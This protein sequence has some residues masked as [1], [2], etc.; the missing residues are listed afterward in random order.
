MTMIVDQELCRACGICGKVCPRFI[1]DTTSDGV[2]R[3]VP[4]RADLCIK[5]G[6]C[7]AVC[8]VDAIKIPAFGDIDLSPAALFGG[9]WTGRFHGSRSTG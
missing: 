1:P 7:A 2:V 9:T 6:H 5:C 4:E 8:P 3:L